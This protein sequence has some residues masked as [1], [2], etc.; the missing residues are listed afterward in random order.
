[1]GLAR[2]YYNVGWTNLTAVGLT[3][4]TYIIRLN[5]SK[6][7]N[8]VVQDTWDIDCIFLHAYNGTNYK[9]DFEYQWTH[10]NYTDA[11]KQV[12]MYITSRTGTE[13]L[14]INYRNGAMWTTIGTITGTG[15]VNVTATGLFS[16]T[17]TIQL[18][19][20]TETADI[21]RGSWNIDCLYLHTWT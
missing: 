10:A 11:Q 3:S 18:I 14:T 7:T 19:G 13:T 15:W 20:A 5:G 16:S 17:Y 1:M 8:D 6:A 2:K 12:C 4:G 9:I 21:E